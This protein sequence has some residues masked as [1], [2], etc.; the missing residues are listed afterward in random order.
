[1]NE[2]YKENFYN[3]INNKSINKIIVTN[4]NN[5]RNSI[6]TKSIYEY[7][8]IPSKIINNDNDKMILYNYLFDIKKN[9]CE[10]SVLLVKN[11]ANKYTFPTVKHI[12]D[13]N[14]ISNHIYS[15]IDSKGYK[16]HIH[17]TDTDFIKKYKIENKDTAKILINNPLTV[18]PQIPESIIYNINNKYKICIF[19]ET[20]KLLNEIKEIKEINPYIY[21]GKIKYEEVNI[22]IE[23]D[24]LEQSGIIRKLNK[25]KEIIH[26]FNTLELLCCSLNINK[27]KYIDDIYD[28]VNYDKI[29][30]TVMKQNEMTTMKQNEMTEY[31]MNKLF[32]NIYTNMLYTNIFQFIKDPLPHKPIDIEFTEF[33]QSS[34]DTVL[35]KE[36]INY[37]TNTYIIKSIHPL[38]IDLYPTEFTK[39]DNIVKYKLQK[40]LNNTKVISPVTYKEINDNL[41]HNNNGYN[42]WESKFWKKIWIFIRD[43]PLGKNMIANYDMPL[44]IIKS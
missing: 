26:N 1:M 7:F 31:D 33:I 17:K 24:N 15:F 40:M 2:M 22:N 35:S 29:F 11:S 36:V 37:F 4:K 23:L 8:D 5:L 32:D 34:E 27:Y 21:N 39:D 41:H 38:F 44:N 30:I 25:F 43:M 9:K 16:Y 6:E 20:S 14:I 28:E 42:L 19:D 3:I 12:K 10:Y 18:H 13:Q